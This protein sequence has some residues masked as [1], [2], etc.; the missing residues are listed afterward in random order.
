M[1]TNGNRFAPESFSRWMWSSTWAW[2]RMCTSSATGSPV[3]VGVVTPVAE[4]GRGE[5]R[6]LGAGV[7]RLASHD[8]P[9]AVRPVGEIDEVGELGDRGAGTFVAVLA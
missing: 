4:Q 6:L 1:S 7:Q 8:Q 3:G 5:Q 9:G 2:A